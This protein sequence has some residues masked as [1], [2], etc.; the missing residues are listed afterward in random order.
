MSSVRRPLPV[1]QTELLV[2]CTA[3]LGRLPALGAWWH[4]ADWTLLARATGLS[5]GGDTPVRWF[6]QVAY[7]EILGP[8]LGTAPGPWAVTR[9]LLHGAAAALVHRLVLRAGGSRAGA[10]AARLAGGDHPLAFDPLYRAG[11]VQELL[12][13]TLALL[14]AERLLAGG[15]R[16]AA[17]AALAGLL[18]V[19]SQECALGLPLWVGALALAATVRAGA[20]GWR[21]PASWRWR[22]ASRPCW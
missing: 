3:A 9:L 7:W 4:G 15:P 22:P 11:G 20:S 12:G 6:S 18:A 1:A 10:L 13:A 21:R 14:C 8:L 19:L 17:A 2:F 16:A 5:G